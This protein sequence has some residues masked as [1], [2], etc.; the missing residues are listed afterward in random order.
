MLGWDQIAVTIVDD[1][2]ITA[3]AYALAA[4]KT[5]ILGSYNEE[6]LTEMIAEVIPEPELLEATGFTEAEIAGMMGETVGLAS[7]EEPEEHGKGGP[8]QHTCPSCGFEWEEEPSGAFRP[9]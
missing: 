9:V 5:G 1:D 4:N 6:F 3:M 7:P 2:D 8:R